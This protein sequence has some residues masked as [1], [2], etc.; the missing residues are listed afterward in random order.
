MSCIR[1]ANALHAVIIFIGTC[2]EEVLNKLT[3]EMY[4][5]SEVDIVILTGDMNARIGTK[6]DCSLDGEVKDRIILDTQ[7]NGQG[8]KLLNFLNDTKTCV[9]NGHVTPEFDAFT[10]LTSHKGKAVVDY[11]VTRISDL[12]AIKISEC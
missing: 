4:K 10:S 12:N 1:F 9:L 11:M 3:I 8:Q 5:N 6:K 7:T 2:N